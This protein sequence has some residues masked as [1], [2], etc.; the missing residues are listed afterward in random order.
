[1]VLRSG[2]I[3]Q[4]GTPQ[5]LYNTPLDTFVADFIGDPP[6]NIIKLT[7]DDPLIKSL[8]IDPRSYGEESLYI[9]F[10]PGEIEVLAKGEVCIEAL[11][12]HTEYQGSRSLSIAKLAGDR[13]IRILSEKSLRP[14]DI[15]CIKPLKI[16][17]FDHIG[18][19]IS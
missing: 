1:M 13:R 16:H 14:G 19:R 10:R 17:I 15:V 6:M 12:E 3:A 5:D 9:G 18:K 11:I 8:N 2:E 7:I 4:I